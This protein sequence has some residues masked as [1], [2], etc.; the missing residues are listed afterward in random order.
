LIDEHGDSRWQEVI[1]LYCGLAP[2]PAA[3]CVI[4]ALVD[5][6]AVQAPLLADAYL[7]SGAELSSDKEL[8]R[9]VLSAVAVAG[10]TWNDAV[11][12]FPEEE[13]APVAN[14]FVG[15]QQHD[16]ICCA[17][18]WLFARTMRI[19]FAHLISRLRSLAPGHNPSG[20]A[21]L[22]FLL[23]YR[24]DEEALAS[25]VG[26]DEMYALPGPVSYETQAEIAIS[27]L[28]SRTAAHND[29][30]PSPG[31]DAA[32]ISALSVVVKSP[33]IGTRF[34]VHDAPEPSRSVWRASR[35]LL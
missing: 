34:L 19:D 29:E 31:A 1:A 15:T 20:V 27:A 28:L 32:F 26:F 6:T 16:G 8:R 4:E 12:R 13:F 14:S 10:G 3:R 18:F 21:D 17:Y 33:K 25:A 24:G 11:D 23:H 7:S 30:E 5:R 9:Q 2:A 35:P 22:N